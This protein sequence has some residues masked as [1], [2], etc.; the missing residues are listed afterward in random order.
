MLL[1]KNRESFYKRTSHRI[2]EEIGFSRAWASSVYTWRFWFFSKSYPARNV[3]I[4]FFFILY[5]Q[6]NFLIENFICIKIL[7]FKLYI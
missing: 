7:F 1:A 2:W 6:L 5:F 3:K 4:Y